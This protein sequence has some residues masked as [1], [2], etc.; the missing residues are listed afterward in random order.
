VL[1]V[2]PMMEQQFSCNKSVYISGT[3]NGKDERIEIAMLLM[4]W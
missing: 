1:I 4:V 3:I 2:P